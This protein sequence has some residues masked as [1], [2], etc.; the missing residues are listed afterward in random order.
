MLIPRD[1]M[2]EFIATQQI[3]NIGQGVEARERH[4]LT[5]YRQQFTMPRCNMVDKIS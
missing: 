1:E 4:T 5:S 2:V 3:W